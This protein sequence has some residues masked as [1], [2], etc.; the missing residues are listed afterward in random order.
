M[1]SSADLLGAGHARQTSPISR[2]ASVVRSLDGHSGKVGDRF[3][4]NHG[5]FTEQNS[6]NNLL[7]FWESKDLGGFISQESEARFS[8]LKFQ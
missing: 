7:R 3:I 6:N 5:A 1:K 2:R 4:L 8:D